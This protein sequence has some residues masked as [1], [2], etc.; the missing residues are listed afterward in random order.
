M[1]REL[2]TV[3]HTLE[4]LILLDPLTDLLN[5]RGLQQALQIICEVAGSRG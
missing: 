5:R 1:T 2:Q 4:K 3:N